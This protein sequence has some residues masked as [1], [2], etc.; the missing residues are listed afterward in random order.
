MSKSKETLQPKPQQPK[1]QQPQPQSKPS[2]PIKD[3]NNELAYKGSV[4][5]ESSG[6]S[7]SP[8]K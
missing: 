2:Q 8:K 5:N 7:G 1:P 3:N 6:P 4:L